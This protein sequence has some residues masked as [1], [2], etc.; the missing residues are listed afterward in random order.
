[1]HY[2]LNKPDFLAAFTDSCAQ[3]RSFCSLPS[4]L[5]KRRSECAGMVLR[6]AP[7]HLA[8]SFCISRCMVLNQSAIW[9]L[10]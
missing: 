3:S 7:L 6:K 8:C 5:R 2:V 9:Q 4:S 10:A 1:M